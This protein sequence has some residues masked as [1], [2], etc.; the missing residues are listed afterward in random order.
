MN[1]RCFLLAEFITPND[2]NNNN[3]N[4]IYMQNESNNIYYNLINRCKKFNQLAFIN[5]F[6]QYF[7]YIYIQ[8]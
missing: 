7:N 2:Y 4:K 8:L 3:N 1:T 5:I 6:Y